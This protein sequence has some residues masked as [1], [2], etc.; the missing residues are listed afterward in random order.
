VI[1]G[2]FDGLAGEY[3][4]ILENDANQIAIVVLKLVMASISSRGALQISDFEL[5]RHRQ[6]EEALPRPT[7]F[8]GLLP[9]YQPMQGY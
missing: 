2:A 4:Q 5:L 1:F 9:Q 7:Q 8:L 6:V 3:G